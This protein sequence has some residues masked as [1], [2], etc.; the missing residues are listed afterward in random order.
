MYK[1]AEVSIVLMVKL[2]TKLS[3]PQ[4]NITCLYNKINNS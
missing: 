2:E 4:I 3:N 1:N